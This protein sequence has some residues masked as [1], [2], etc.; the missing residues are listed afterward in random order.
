MTLRGSRVL[1]WHSPLLLLLILPAASSLLSTVA[2]G[3]PLA[4]F[5]AGRQRATLKEKLREAAAEKDES[6]I[7]TLV[8]E[9]ALLNP[10]KFATKGLGVPDEAC[11]LEGRWELLYTNA[12]DAEAPARTENRLGS[13]DNKDEIKK[14]VEISTG[15]EINGNTGLCTNFISLSG[16]GRPFDRLDIEIQMTAISESRVRLDF[17][18]G[19][20]QNQAA[21]FPFL[22]DVSF[23]FPPPAAGDV[24]ARIRGKDPAVAPQAYFDILY[25]DGDFRAHRTGEGKVFVQARPN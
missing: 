22:K 21:P 23:S 24:L 8:D 5:A 18:R 11:P 25:I 10:S 14:G 17:M 12:R 1:S 6:L 15:Q 4:A 3:N 19:R 7:L 20:A 13:F 16:D 2:K 9:L